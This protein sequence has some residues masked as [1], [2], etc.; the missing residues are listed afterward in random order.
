MGM[1][2]LFINK[3]HQDMYLPIF[4][5]DRELVLS[6]LTEAMKKMD[7]VEVKSPERQSRAFYD[8]A[9]NL[10]LK[11]SGAEVFLGPEAASE[12]CLGGV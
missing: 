6:V 3:G 12:I 2:L 1:G 10:G 5:E 8:I 9:D 11:K 4:N 7:D